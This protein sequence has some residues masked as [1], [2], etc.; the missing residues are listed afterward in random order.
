MSHHAMSHH[1][2]SADAMS[3]HTTSQEPSRPPGRG[4]RAAGG[5]DLGVYLITDTALCGGPDGVVRTAIAARDGGAS[6]VQLRD[7]RAST[8]ELAELGR[9]LLAALAGDDRLVIINDRVDIALAIG[10]D[11]AHVG[12][13]DM[14]PLDARR[15][16]GPYRH[17]GLSV[18]S[19][20]EAR[21]AARL[22]AGTIDLLGVGPIRPT[23]SKP[24]A[25][26]AM[27]W[28]GFEQVCAVAAVPCV[29][30]GG[31]VA[32]DAPTVRRA[33]GSGM[34]VISAICGQPDPAA[35]ARQLRRAWDATTAG[36][37]TDR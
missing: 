11:G 10:A 6:A 17:L 2:V 5:S 8:R 37:G 28:A 32:Q 26:P 12:Q 36:V 33:G 30:I 7:P 9:A 31:V 13:Q 22:P 3:P 25:A 15:L 20:Q 16:L 1:A 27:G 19:V 21:D 24:E 35:A 34:A 18:T 14:D 4:I 23:R 29:A